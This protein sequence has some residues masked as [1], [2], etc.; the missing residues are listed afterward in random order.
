MDC[1]NC[2]STLPVKA[3]FC[4]S[5]GAPIRLFGESMVDCSLSRNADHTDEQGDL[6]PASARINAESRARLLACYLNFSISK[7]L[8]EWLEDLKLPSTG[9]THEKLAR[10]R[11]YTGSLV[12]AAETPRGPGAS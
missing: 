6:T 2:G 11:Q 12:L 9:T 10:L 5:C 7:E 8:S 4:P 3:R 1:T